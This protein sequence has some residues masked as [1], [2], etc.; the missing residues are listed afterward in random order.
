[1]CDVPNMAVFCSALIS[2]FPDMLLA[3]FLNDFIIII[4]IIDNWEDMNGVLCCAF[5]TLAWVK[6]MHM[7]CF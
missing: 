6:G 1:M 4:I 5:D 3:Y 2:C 7:I